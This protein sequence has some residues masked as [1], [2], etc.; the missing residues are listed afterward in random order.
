MRWLKELE[1]SGVTVNI[2]DQPCVSPAGLVE[3][4]WNALVP[5]DFGTDCT[6]MYQAFII[7]TPLRVF[8]TEQARVKKRTKLHVLCNCNANIS[9]TLKLNMQ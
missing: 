6:G 8:F 5:E 9:A 2:D 4:S 3:A 7:N 1:L